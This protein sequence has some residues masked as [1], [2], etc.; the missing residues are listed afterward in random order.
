MLNPPPY[1]P[2]FP[3]LGHAVEILPTNV[4]GDNQPFSFYAGYN[5]HNT[6]SFV[7]LVYFESE[8]NYYGPHE[9]GML[10]RFVVFSV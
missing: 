3:S 6:F 4:P 7:R 5:I 2:Y 9:D 10:V 1:P 8:P